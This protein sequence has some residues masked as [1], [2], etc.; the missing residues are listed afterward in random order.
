MNPEDKNIYGGTSPKTLQKS[1][2][3]WIATGSI[4]LFILFALGVIVFLYNQNQTLKEKLA[5]YQSTP[6]PTVTEKATPSPVPGTNT[7]VVFSPVSGS[8]VKSP[9]KII[10]KVPAGWMFEGSFPITLLDSNQ[11]V[12]SQGKA[13]EVTAGSWQNENPVDFEATLT[14]KGASG[15]GNLVLQNDNPS[16]NP[17]N[18]KTFV[19]PINF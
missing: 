7:P 13:K 17:A 5:N 4:A 11:K 3:N 19:V 6:A 8:V 10:G 16:G 14:F 1:H 9:L 18:A 2:N 12:I 15:S